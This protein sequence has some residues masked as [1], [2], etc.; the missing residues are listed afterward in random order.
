MSFAQEIFCARCEKRFG[1]SQLLNL[2][3]CGSP[4]LVRYDLKNAKNTFVKSSLQ[5]RV[6]S[7]WRYRELLPLQND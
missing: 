7:L 1:L 6:A 4:L 3:P 2:C 5:G